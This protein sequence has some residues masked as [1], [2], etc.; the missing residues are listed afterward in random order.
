[1]LSG[2]YRN[3]DVS[4]KVRPD[5]NWYQPQSGDGEAEWYERTAFAA[6]NRITSCRFTPLTYYS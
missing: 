6:A 1:M 4:L 3:G 5:M 2:A